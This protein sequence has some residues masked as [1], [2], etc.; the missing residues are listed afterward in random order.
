M[1]PR[2]ALPAGS[3]TLSTENQELQRWPDALWTTHVC[4]V[5]C[6]LPSCVVLVAAACSVDARLEP[7]A[8][9][10]AAAL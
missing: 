9:A 5:V 2:R 6:L 8:T 10:A 3:S 1:R 4:P 7:S